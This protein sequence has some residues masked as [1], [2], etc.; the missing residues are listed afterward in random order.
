MSRQPWETNAWIT[1][2]SLLHNISEE[3]QASRR[4]AQFPCAGN[5]AEMWR[6]RRCS[7]YLIVRAVVKAVSDL[8]INFT[9]IV[10]VQSAKGQA[11]IE[12]QVAIRDIQ[13]GD[14]K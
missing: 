13:P 5:T 14:P 2:S 4:A 3:Q 8:S 11:V 9:R 7:L 10:V 6:K 12:Q 1:E